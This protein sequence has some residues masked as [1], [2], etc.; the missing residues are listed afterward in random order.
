[1]DY[2][3]SGLAPDDCFRKRH[4]SAAVFSWRA[5]KMRRYQHRGGNDRKRQDSRD[6]EAPATRAPALRRLRSRRAVRPRLRHDRRLVAG[7]R[8][9]IG[10]GLNGRLG[11]S[12]A[13]LLLICR[14]RALGFYRGT[15]TLPYFFRQ[16][17]RCRLS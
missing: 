8:N 14:L 9:P 17:R 15:Q 7:W 11:L 2:P 12:G 10:P 4:G 1:M 6:D 16:Q 5:G 3:A 13:S